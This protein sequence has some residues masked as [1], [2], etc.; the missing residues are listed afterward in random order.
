[1]KIG[2]KQTKEVV[3][4]KQAPLPFTGQKRMFLKHFKA[5]LNEQ[6]P[7]DGEGW[8]ISMDMLS[9]WHILTTLM[10]FVRCFTR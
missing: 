10:H 3:M 4:F 9:D 8:T 5:I 7:G 6:I 1:M 2:N